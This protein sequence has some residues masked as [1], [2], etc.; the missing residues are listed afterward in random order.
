M[1]KDSEPPPRDPTMDARLIHHI[2][3]DIV[4]TP[5]GDQIVTTV[6]NATPSNDRRPDEN[7]AQQ[8]NEPGSSPLGQ[9]PDAHP[10]TAPDRPNG[11]PADHSGVHTDAD[12]PSSEAENRIMPPRSQERG[13]GHYKELTDLAQNVSEQFQAD[14]ALIEGSRD[15]RGYAPAERVILTGQSP[16][17]EGQPPGNDAP[18]AP[19]ANEQLAATMKELAAEDAPNARDAAAETAR[20]QSNDE[21]AKRQDGERRANAGEVQLDTASASTKPQTA[22]DRLADT[23]TELASEAEP[24]NPQQDGGRSGTP[25]SGRGAF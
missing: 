1:S 20:N 6:Y 22:R 23:M 10:P 7:A 13:P 11:D 16:P 5:G 17:P 25:P 21:S 4:P 8:P 2:R 9:G 18:K 14:L 19:T 24:K 12:S 3:P 15:V